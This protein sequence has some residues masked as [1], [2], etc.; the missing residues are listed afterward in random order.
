MTVLEAIKL[1]TEFFEKKGI[2]EARINAELLLAHIL[3]CKR[4]ALYL[5][6]DKPLKEEEVTLYR[7]YL[8]R[9]AKY[10]PLQYITGE[11]EFYGLP[12]QVR[13]GVLIP[14]PDTEILAETVLSSFEK[15]NILKFLDIGTGSGILAVVLAKN[16]PEATIEAMDK[17]AAALSI[18]RENA[19]INSVEGKIRFFEGNILADGIPDESY[20][21][22]VSNP[23]YIAY[24]EYKTL[25]PEV[26]EFEPKEALT[27]GEDGYTFYR[28]ISE[29]AQ[30]ILKPSGML[31]F[32]AGKGQYE[33]IIKIME[34][35]GFSDIAV[36]KDYQQIERVIYGVKK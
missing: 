18:A 28:V 35:T 5:S 24:D 6:F 9:R 14:R 4:L 13:E 27:D 20:D 10:E 32:E 21:V 19:A 8:K 3:K 33:E 17:S 29:R 36:K 31:F 1:S 11:V 34:S 25:L 12:F 22:I 26:L 7:E 30:K 2:K 23:P 16:F 15:N